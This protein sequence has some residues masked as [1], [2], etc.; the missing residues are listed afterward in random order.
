M[1]PDNVDSS[2][3]GFDRDSV[4]TST[5]STS[6]EDIK[7]NKKSIV[8]KFMHEE[9][10]KNGDSIVVC[11]ECPQKYS[12]NTS[13]GVLAE[14]LNNKHN[15][16]IILKSRRYLSSDQSPY[17]KD[18]IICIEECENSILNFFVSDQISFNIAESRWF[19]KITN[20][21]DSRY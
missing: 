13:T 8:W 2:E 14:H 4:T 19:H 7:S 15:H 17:N 5:S 11:N 1:D 10:D 3:E 16:G 9:K 21:L 6:K 18:D 20:T 12:I